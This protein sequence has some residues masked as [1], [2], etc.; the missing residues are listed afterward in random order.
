MPL[1][2]DNQWLRERSDELDATY[3]QEVWYTH[4]VRPIA[5]GLYHAGQGILS[6]NGDELAHSRDQFNA[7]GTGQTN[8]E[9]Y[10]QRVLR[11]QSQ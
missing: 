2:E 1:E 6:L 3:G 4:A 11:Q 10:E 9:Y 5:H 8:N 7:V